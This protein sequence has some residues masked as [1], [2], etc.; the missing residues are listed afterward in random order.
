M[1]IIKTLIGLIAISISIMLTYAVGRITV[2]VWQPDTTNPDTE[3]V[4]IAGL[5]GVL[6]VGFA[7]CVCAAAS[8]LGELVVRAIA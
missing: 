3:T 7:V 6:C 5:L 1:I 4:L 8:L 2:Q